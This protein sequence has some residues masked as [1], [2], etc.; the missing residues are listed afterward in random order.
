MAKCDVNVPS[1]ERRNVV[2]CIGDQGL[3]PQGTF[4]VRSK[5]VKLKRLGNFQKHH[6]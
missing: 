2:I 5:K 6:E 4:I 3:G 1:L